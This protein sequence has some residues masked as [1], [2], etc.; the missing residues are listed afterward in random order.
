V[1]KVGLQRYEQESKIDPAVGHALSK[2]VGILSV[3]P[4]GPKDEAGV[5][6]AAKAWAVILRKH[7]PT[8]AEI[9]GMAVPLLE[10]NR[11]FPVPM[12]AVTILAEVR[13]SNDEKRL[14][15][16]VDC[17]DADGFGYLAPPSR[18]RNGLLLPPGDRSGDGSPARQL[19][20][21]ARVLGAGGTEILRSLGYE[22]REREA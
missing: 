9:E 2:L 14:A 11:F 8:A 6:L 17:I 20:T 15:G 10:R 3:L 7:N 19:P 21:G 4:N 22:P 18:V 16:Y 13:E 1:E 12:D 5:Q